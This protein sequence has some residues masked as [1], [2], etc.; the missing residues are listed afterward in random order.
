MLWNQISKTL[1]QF[2]L[3][4]GLGLLLSQG[5]GIGQPAMAASASASD[6]PP[7]LE[8]TVDDFLQDIPRGFYAVRDVAKIQAKVAEGKT[9]FIDVREPSEYAGGHIPEAI[10]IPLRELAQSLDQVPHD[11]PVMLYC[12]TG[13]RTGIGVMALRLLGYDNVEGFP[14]SYE[15]WKQAQ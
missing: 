10:N 2:V 1:Q 4:I 15:G 13:Y 14:P 3:I 8:A 12:S 5:W 9:L 11:Q 7:G 6:T